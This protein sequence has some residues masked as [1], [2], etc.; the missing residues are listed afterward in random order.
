MILCEDNG[1]YCGY[2]VSVSGHAEVYRYLT[3]D[4]G[5]SEFNMWMLEATLKALC[6]HRKLEWGYF[7]IFRGHSA[8]VIS[9]SEVKYRIM[10]VSEVI[11]RVCVSEM[12]VRVWYQC[13][14]S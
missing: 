1:T 4:K 2:Y 13:Q 3:E 5:Q 7:A 10:L 12:I 8:D 6:E 14:S 9:V 11:D